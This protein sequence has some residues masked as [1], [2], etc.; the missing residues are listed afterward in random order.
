MDIFKGYII[1]QIQTLRFCVRILT[2]YLFISEN[3][4]VGFVNIVF[5]I[6][7]P[8]ILKLFGDRRPKRQY[9]LNQSI[10][11]DRKYMSLNLALLSALIYYV[12]GISC[13]VCLPLLLGEHMNPFSISL[14]I[15]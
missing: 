13:R 3:N 15:G 6:I 1:Y 8:L 2:D 5:Y 4:V 7:Y 14:I 12:S 10:S 11:T 9:N